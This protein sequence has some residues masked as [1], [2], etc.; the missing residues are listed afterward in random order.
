MGKI[1][2][3]ISS[4]LIAL[5]LSTALGQT[6]YEWWLDNDVSGRKSG[7]FSGSRLDLRVDM[8][9]MSEGL[10]GFN[11]RVNRNDTTWGAVYHKTILIPASKENKTAEAYEY[12][13]DD[14][15][16]AKESGSLSAGVNAYTVNFKG[17]SEG[18]HRLN[19]RVRARN[20][21]WG[22][23]YSQYFLIPSSKTDG[24]AEEYEYWIDDNFNAKESGSLSASVNA[25]TVKLNEMTEGLHRLNYRV[26]T[27]DGVWSSIYSQYFLIPSSQTDGIAV[28]YEYWIDDNYDAKQSGSLSTGSNAYTV[29]LKELPEGLHRFN[30]RVRTQYGDWGSIYSQFFCNILPKTSVSTY[31]YW[32][33]NDFA[34]RKTGTVEENQMTF[35]VDLEGFDKSG[36]FHC[37]N[38]RVHDS[39]KGWSALYRK[40]LVFHSFKEDTKAIG[41]RH[42]LNGMDLGY[43]EIEGGIEK[44]YT[45]SVA[46]PDGLDLSPSDLGNLTFNGDEVSSEWNDSIHYTIQFK[47]AIGWSSPKTWDYALSR[48]FSTTATGMEVN[49]SRDFD[50]P[51]SGEFAAVKFTSTGAPLYFRAD[52][53][54]AL[55]VYRDGMKV[56]EFTASEIAGTSSA[57]LEAGEYF[58]ILHHV[59]DE[60]IRFSFHLTDTPNGEIPDMKCV[61]VSFSYN[62]RYLHI[63]TE[64]QGASILYTSDGSDPADGIKYDGDIDVKGLGLIRAVAVKEGYMN[65]DTEELLINRYADE[66]HAETAAEGLLASAFEWYRELPG[67]VTDFRIVG[68]LNGEDYAFIRSMGSLR[69]LDMEDV[70]DA[71]I[72]ANAFRDS[73]L[74]SV[75]LPEDFVECGDSILSGAPLLSSVIWN[76]RSMDVG[77]GLTGGLENPNV[78]LYIPE[79]TNVSGRQDLN[80]VKD[81]NAESII[82]RYGHPYYAARGFRADEV[83]L[84]H[85]FTQTTIPDI[86]RGWETMVLP[87]SPTGITHEV[88]GPAVP[89][90]AWNGDI[91]GDRPFWLHRATP[92]GWEA[93]SSMEACVPYIISMPNSSE[94]IEEFNLGGKVTFSAEDVYLGPE[95]SLAKA[96]SWIDGTLFE[97]TFMAVDSAGILSLNVGST[98]GGLQPGSTFVADGITVPFG[99]YVSGAGRKTMPLFGGAS[100]IDLPLTADAGLV[101]E[102]PA[103][104]TLRI[105]SG[106]ERRVAVTTA[107][108][109]TIRILH[110]RPGDTVT[111][112]GLTR[113]LYIVG[114]RKVMVR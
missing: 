104:G 39:E 12:W 51:G 20:G 48:G 16:D 80:I 106:R 96:D 102:T 26:R 31:E 112:E 54:V 25:Y 77:E 110:L 81:D 1:N 44:I 13:I 40:I 3:I 70:A 101:I 94:Y 108:G 87:F 105:C 42:S 55:D 22:S 78:L 107:T 11:C 111:L 15:Y 56:R 9:G 4:F 65:S 46:I 66:E 7:T 92:G 8:S 10:H 23:T 103:P 68:R 19:Y 57:E 45:F 32:L 30:Y 88:N 73:R 113:D 61:G 109:V 100:G 33:D 82:L 35:K 24:T 91:E 63:E 67:K 17:N 79:G 37:F 36:D 62:G 85:E 86:C 29:D 93:S 6:G 52:V 58:G 27:R 69:H 18:M 59:A 64:E 53:P 90:A 47:S 34:N 84:T 5:C 97:G 95:S 14:N 74:I 50:A 99:A 43:V 28:A 89:F 71:H 21:V 114:G 60:A 76:S 38:M 72:P 83:T 98:D 49:S 75:S 2:S 41:Y